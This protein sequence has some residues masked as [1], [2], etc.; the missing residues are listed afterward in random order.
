MSWLNTESNSHQ[1]SYSVTRD[2][3]IHN[4]LEVDILLSRDR[5]LNCPNFLKFIQSV[6]YFCVIQWNDNSLSVESL[7]SI[8]IGNTHFGSD[9][10]NLQVTFSIQGAFKSILIEII[11]IILIIMTY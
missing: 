9:H 5:V 1:V 11:E 10:A 3:F 8:I 6:R 2:T 4:C 7:G